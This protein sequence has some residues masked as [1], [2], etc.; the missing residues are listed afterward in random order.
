LFILEKCLSPLNDEVVKIVFQFP[1][2]LIEGKDGSRSRLYRKGIDFGN[3]ILD[4]IDFDVVDGKTSGVA[5]KFRH[6]D[7]LRGL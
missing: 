3:S 4:A 7:E 5:Y 1:D 2:L 6:S